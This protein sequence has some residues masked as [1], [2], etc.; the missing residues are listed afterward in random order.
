[1]VKVI[2]VVVQEMSYLFHRKKWC[3]LAGEFNRK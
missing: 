1:M 2:I 3:R